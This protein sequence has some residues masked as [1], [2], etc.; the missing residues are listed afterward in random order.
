MSP[1]GRSP[2]RLACIL[3]TLAVTGRA[4]DD[5]RQAHGTFTGAVKPVLYVADVEKSAPFYRDVLG[6]EFQ[7]FANTKGEP[8]Y[9]EMVA[10]E[11]KFGLHEP[12]SSGQE[13]RV[14]QQRLYFRVN[15]LEPHHA[16]VVAWGGEPGEIKKTAWM[17]MFIV[18][19]PDG[20][21]IVF[22]VTDPD[23]HSIN[24]WNTRVEAA[25]DS[26]EGE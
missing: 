10:G 15:D 1:N 17:D 16:R 13:A 4:E 11:Q 12:T 21:E 8:Y 9:A 26:G 18:R 14:G 6:F 20:N 3:L 5:P 2:L 23:R 25:P 7:G 19:D 22:A 24:P